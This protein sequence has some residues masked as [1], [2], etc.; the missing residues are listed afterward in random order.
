MSF[1]MFLLRY[2]QWTNLSRNFAHHWFRWLT[3]DFQAH[4]WLD[5]ETLETMPRLVLGTWLTSQLYDAFVPIDWKWTK[6]YCV[7]LTQQQANGEPFYNYSIRC[8]H[9]LSTGILFLLISS[10][11]QI[12]EPYRY[13]RAPAPQRQ[14]QLLK[15]TFCFQIFSKSM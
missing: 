11:K 2:I 15:S 5:W 13:W 7:A 4:A 12:C 3:G 8:I 14:R 1:V 6:M 10:W 9:P